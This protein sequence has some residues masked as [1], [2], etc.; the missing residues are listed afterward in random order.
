MHNKI[1]R[2]NEYLSVGLSNCKG[3]AGYNH[4]RGILWWF[5]Q[6]D[7]GT[8]VYQDLDLQYYSVTDYT[9]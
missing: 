1:D 8:K 7:P 5:N 3:N 4:F 9:V 6:Y 2:W